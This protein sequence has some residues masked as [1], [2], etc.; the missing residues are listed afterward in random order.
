MPTT[1]T[2]RHRVASAA[3]MTAGE[4]AEYLRMSEEWV[5]LAGRRGTLPTVTIGSAVRYRRDDLEKFVEANR[6]VAS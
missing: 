4:A 2:K 6:K 3:L 1:A 5:R